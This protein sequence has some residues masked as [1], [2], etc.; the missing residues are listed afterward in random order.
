MSSG[1]L[2]SFAHRRFAIVW[3][4][5]ACSAVGTW[6]QIV[7]QSLVTLRITHGSAFALGAVLLAQAAAF[8]LFALAGGGIADAFNRRKLLLV[9]QTVLGGLAALLGYLTASGR[10]EL[11][12]LLVL[13]FMTG[14][15]LSADQ[16]ARAALLPTLVPDAER[17]NAIALQS[18]IFQ[19]ASIAGPTLA[20]VAAA[21]IGY[22]GCFYLNAVS[23]LAV[24]IALL[25]AGGAGDGHRPARQRLTQAVAELFAT[26]RRDPVLRAALSGYAAVLFLTPSSALLLPVLAASVWRIPAARLGQLCACSGIGAVAGALLVAHRG[27]HGSKSTAYLAGLFTSALALGAFPSARPLA[28]VA[29]LLVVAGAGQATTSVITAALLQGRV[30]PDL[31]GRVMSLNT[32]LVMGIRPLGDF[33]EGLLIH[34][35]G[36]QRAALLCAG[37]IVAAGLLLLPRRSPFHSV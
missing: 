37:F 22:A 20:G 21:T 12:M 34:V 5:M 35:A 7:A 24:L 33:P 14:C 15:V 32:L 25:L 17:T 11:W 4:G 2:R 13:A 1:A 9:S 16:P 19:G 29:A 3:S 23:Y 30:P 8:L 31:R 36:P 18:M 6:M 28:L 10:I 26:L 27:D